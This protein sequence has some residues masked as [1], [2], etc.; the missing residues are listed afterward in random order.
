MSCECFKSLEVSSLPTYFPWDISLSF[1]LYLTGMKMTVLE[2]PSLTSIVF[3][4]LRLCLIL[5]ESC[6]VFFYTRYHNEIQ[7]SIKQQVSLLNT[8]Y[9]VWRKSAWIISVFYKF[10]FGGS[11]QNI[12]LETIILLSVSWLSKKILKFIKANL[13]LCTTG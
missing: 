4:F 11:T 12:R 3:N 5:Q 13:L 2:F 7:S 6:A 1:S 9:N 10:S 8:T